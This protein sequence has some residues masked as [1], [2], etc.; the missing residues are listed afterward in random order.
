METSRPRHALSTWPGGLG[1]RCIAGPHR[2]GAW[3]RKDG[4]LAWLTRYATGGE[5]SRRLA[6][7]SLVVIRDPGRQRRHG[8][9]HRDRAAG[10]I[11]FHVIPALA[12][13]SCQP[14]CGHGKLACQHVGSHVDDLAA[15]LL[16]LGRKTSW[17]CRDTTHP[18]QSRWCISERPPWWRSSSRWP[19]LSL[20]ALRDDESNTPC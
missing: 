6:G 20:T 18:W 5:R 9:R 1:R 3:Q 17:R 2:P 4:S 13:S 16:S 10:S 15:G 7:G 19:S 14:A 8:P 11:F 12:P